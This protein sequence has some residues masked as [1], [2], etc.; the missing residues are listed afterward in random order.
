[1]SRGLGGDFAVTI[2]DQIPAN[3]D[4]ATAT[5]A[6]LPTDGDDIDNAWFQM[7]PQYIYEFMALLLGIDPA[8][9]QCQVVSTVSVNPKAG[10]GRPRA[11]AMFLPLT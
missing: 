10:C 7:V 8:S 6:D 2:D 1:M 3:V 5:A 4:V 11:S 9:T